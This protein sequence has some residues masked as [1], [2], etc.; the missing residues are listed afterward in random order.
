MYIKCVICRFPE[1]QLQRNTH[2]LLKGW[3][4]FKSVTNTFKNSTEVHQVSTSMESPCTF[5]ISGNNDRFT[6]FHENFDN[7]SSHNT[8]SHETSEIFDH[9]QKDY[10]NQINKIHYY[11]GDEITNSSTAS[12]ASLPNIPKKCFLGGTQRKKKYS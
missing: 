3:Q 9:T 5:D 7:S 11:T 8:S 12:T 1:N 2:G 6:P 10:S 4:N